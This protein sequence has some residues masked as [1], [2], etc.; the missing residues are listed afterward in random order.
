MIEPP[1]PDPPRDIYF[2]AE[3]G[4]WILSRYADVLAALQHPKLWSVGGDRE[5]QL[6]GRDDSGR[7]KTRGEVAARFSQSHI[8]AWRVRMEE[9]ARR[10]IAELP[11]ERPVDLLGEF[12]APWALS[13]AILATGG[14]TI[15]REHLARLSARV[16]A[17]TGASEH[18]PER[19]DASGATAELEEINRSIPL[20][21]PTFV[22][23]SQTTPRLIANAW[24][25]LIANPDEYAQLRANP[26][27]MP[28][29]VEELLRFSGIVRRVYRRATDSIELGGADI[30]KGALLSLMLSS[31]NRDPGQFPDPE[32]LQLDRPL[33]NQLALGYGRNACVGAIPVR[34]AIAVST[35]ALTSSFSTIELRGVGEWR[36]GSGFYFPSSVDVTL[37]R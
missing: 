33:A 16:F 15:D 4:S 32:R 12:A 2:D 7:L 14:D 30:P 37:L 28:S 19:A 29:A 21:E 8:N 35:A 25:A 11:V 23:L 26:E 24:L 36:I 20:G 5:I 27:M 13:L 17:A 18:S 9:E 34:A 6:E 22:A 31:A 3:Q 1:R 10:M